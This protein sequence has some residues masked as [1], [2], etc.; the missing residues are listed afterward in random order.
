M[1]EIQNGNLIG[2]SSMGFPLNDF[3]N[4]SFVFGSGDII[5][6][7]W[8]IDQGRISFSRRNGIEKFDLFPQFL[9][10][11]DSF[12]FFVSLV[13]PGDSVEIVDEN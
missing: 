9:N 4:P 10:N 3:D 2:I 8:S 7:E 6:M 5:D 11:V 12:K 13:V 1:D